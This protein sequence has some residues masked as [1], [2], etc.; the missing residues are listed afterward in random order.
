MPGT[1]YEVARRELVIFYVLDTSGSMLDD[2]KIGVLNEAM[3]ETTEVLRHISKSNA[4]ARLKLAIMEFNTGA[5]W[6]T[7]DGPIDL[8]DF[9]WDDLRAGGLTDIGWAMEELNQKMSRS[10]FLYSSTGA[11]QFLPVVIF[12]S[13]GMPTDDWEERLDTLNSTNKWFQ[14]AIKMAFALGDSADEKVLARIVGNREAV[15]KTNDLVLFKRLIKCVSATASMLATA[16]RTV[17]PD[18]GAIVQ[19]AL[20]NDVEDDEWTGNVGTSG[21]RKKKS[22]DPEI[23]GGDPNGPKTYGGDPNGPDDGWD[24]DD[25]N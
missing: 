10:E 14:R 17:A 12:M 18:G 4:D 8:E 1:G 16:S 20:G 23:Y 3:R 25:W 6:L 2:G 24:D 21:N 5:R 22:N 19:Q 9:F 7:P 11:G 13:D 15:V